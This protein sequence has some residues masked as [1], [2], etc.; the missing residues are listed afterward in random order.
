MSASPPGGPSGPAGPGGATGPAAELSP[1]RWR[2]D[3]LQLLDQTR[4]P[5]D[6]VWL[7]CRSP[8]QVAD[9]IRRLAVRGAPAIGVAAAYGL[10]LGMAAERDPRR[11]RER[12]EEV[13][14]LLAATR[15]TAVNLRWALA[16]GRK[17]FESAAAEGAEA[18]AGALARWA[19]ALQDED[20]RINRRIGE[21][22]ARLFAEGARVL[23]HC[24]AGALATAGYG[25]ALGVIQ[26]AWR[27]RRLALVWV[28]ETRPLLQGARLTAWE[29]QRLGIPFRLVTDSS[30]GSLMAQGLVDRI[31]VGADR[32]AANG[33]TANKIGTYMVAVL[34]RRHGVP[35]YVAAPL[36]TIDR[37]TPDGAAIPIEQRQP[38][39]V[40]EVFGTTI[41][42]PATEAVNFAFDVTPHDLITAIITEAGVLA[43]PFSESIAAAFAS[44][45]QP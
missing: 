44:S 33:D 8:E 2:G 32:I 27:Q 17:V 12:F 45:G 37:E 36:S 25:T 42:P 13:A 5:V 40:T 23:T 7:D 24:N 18:V 20:V 1:L 16:L 38:G 14:G 10:A 6:E 39:E 19:Q 34:A 11:L 28:D 43:D 9:A 31:V 21:H 41:A 15:P 22:G 29:L 35:F 4:L 26:S 3:S 30:A